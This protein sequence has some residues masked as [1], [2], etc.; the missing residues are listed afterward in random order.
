MKTILKTIT[1]IILTTSLFLTI[2]SCKKEAGPAGADGTNGTNGNANVKSQTDTVTTWT[3][4]AAGSYKYSNIS[5]PNLTA[6]IVANGAVL[7]YLKTTSGTWAPL[8]RTIALTASTSMNQRFVYTTGNVQIII[9]NSDL[10]QP[11]VSSL[12]FKIVCIAGSAMAKQKDV[13]FRNY[14]AVKETFSLVN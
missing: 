9:Q 2:A 8:A 4:D 6:D 14:T 3:W 5:V 11:T 10:S 7:V 13:D 1:A 12:T